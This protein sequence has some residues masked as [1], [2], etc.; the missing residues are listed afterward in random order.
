MAAFFFAI[1][2]VGAVLLVMVLAPE[3][4]Y[5]P[6]SIVGTL[7]VWFR[8]QRVPTGIGLFTLI[9]IALWQLRERLPDVT[10]RVQAFQT[11][12]RREQELERQRERERSRGLVRS[13]DRGLER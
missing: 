1:P 5:V 13:K 2:L 11:V 8:D 9:E 7:R 4:S 3:D 12:Q 6:T 10:Q